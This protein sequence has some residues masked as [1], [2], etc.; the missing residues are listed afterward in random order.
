MRVVK[1]VAWAACTFFV[2]CTG[3]VAQTAVPD[4]LYINGKVITVDDQ[5]RIVEAVAVAGERILAVGSNDELQVMA[6]ADTEIIDLGGRTVIPG[7]IDNHNHVVRATE[8]WPNDARLDGVTSR[9]KALEV[10]KAKADTLPPGEWL[11]GLGGWNEAQFTDSQADF[12]LAELDQ[13]APDRPFF[14]Q[15]VYHHAYANSAWFEEMGI[16][17]MKAGGGEGLDAY[18]VR[19][20]SGNCAGPLPM[21]T[22]SA[23]RRSNERGTWV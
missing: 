21:P 4:Q 15:S 9:A 10:L 23:R 19:D 18:V 14:L 8:Y 12:T 5:F 13:V 11:M 16:S 22:T 2:I 6:G 3:V 7:L 17:L 1:L 20:A